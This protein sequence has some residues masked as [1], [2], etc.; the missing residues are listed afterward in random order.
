MVDQRRALALHALEQH[1][2]L[3]GQLL[4]GRVEDLHQAG[5]GRPAAP[6]WPKPLAAAGPAAAGNRRAAP[7]ARGGA[8]AAAAA[9]ES[10]A[11]RPRGEA[12]RQRSPCRSGRSAGRSPPPSSATRS[13]PRTSSEA[14]ARVSRTARSHSAA[15]WRRSGSHRSATGRTRARRSRP[16]PTPARGRT[17]GASGPT[18]ASRSQSA[19]SP[20]WY[21]RNCQ[22]VSPIAGAA[23][24]VHAR[25]HGGG[26][27]VGLD[28]QRR[29]TL[30]ERLGRL[31]QPAAPGRGGARRGLRRHAG[32]GDR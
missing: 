17:G 24:A 28:Q 20:A 22:K 7:A 5:R 30:A 19:A 16:P 27:P 6:N 29:Q 9:A 8:A 12:A 15:A 18:G 25:R 11:R 21:W 10:R 23:A 2:A 3:V 14:S 13:P 26:D 32:R 4:L 31:A 1:P